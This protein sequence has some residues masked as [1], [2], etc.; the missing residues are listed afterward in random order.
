MSDDLSL[1]GLMFTLD[2]HFVCP[3]NHV[4]VA[5]VVFYRLRADVKVEYLR[6]L[7]NKLLLGPM[8]GMRVAT[9]SEIDQYRLGEQAEIDME[10]G[11]V[12]VPGTTEAQ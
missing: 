6:D 12:M 11:Y 9:Q 2:F 5:R 3:E 4:H 7:Q 1:P 10:P 8:A